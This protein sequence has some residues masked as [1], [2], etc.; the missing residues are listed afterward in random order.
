MQRAS[1]LRPEDDGVS[2]ELADFG[3]VRS[4]ALLLATGATYRRLRLPALDALNGTGV[5]YGGPG[6]EV[7]A[8]GGRDV[9]VLGGANSAGQAALYLARY[10]ASV[11]LVVRAS[12]LDEGMS[13]YLVQQVEATPNV[14]VRLRTEVVGGGGDGW[15]EHLVLRNRV[16]DRQQT[17]AAGGLFLMIGARPRTAWLPAELARDDQGFVLTG[18]DLPPDAPWPLERRPHLLET[19]VPR[20][21]AAGDV[22]HG[23]GRRVAAAVGEGAVVIQLVHQLFA[24]DRRQ[25]GGRRREPLLLG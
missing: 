15:L 16:T 2:V 3:R 5:F 21:Y 1:D 9:F 4:H 24:Y 23:N 13:H 10:A 12:S 6:S 19:S 11:T 20:V 14:Q 18:G 25:P 7:P 8:M 17:V 22:R